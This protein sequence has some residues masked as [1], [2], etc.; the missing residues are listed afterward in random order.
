MTTSS[1]LMTEIVVTC[2]SVAPAILY[3]IVFFLF[4]GPVEATSGPDQPEIAASLAVE[5]EKPVTPDQFRLKQDGDDDAPSI[6]RAI[7][8]LSRSR[9]NQ[10][11]FLPHPYLLRS[12]IIQAD[13]SVHWQGRGWCEP[14]GGASGPQS[15]GI[16]TWLVV[17]RPD[18]TPVTITGPGTRGTVVDDLA[19]FEKQPAASNDKQWQPTPYPYV[20]RLEGTYGLV[21]FRHIMLMAVTRGINAHLSGRLQIDGLLGQVFDNAVKVDKAYD[22]DTYNNIH[23]WP[24][25]SNR[26]RS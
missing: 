15:L 26:P 14:A 23:L 6:N 5:P 10:L 17:D 19:V 11:D 25:W 16:G 3:A 20:F 2:K 13:V 21:L 1:G 22:A 8:F 4:C 9:R 12:P 18:F 24:F 7:T